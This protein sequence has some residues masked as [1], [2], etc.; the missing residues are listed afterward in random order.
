[1][2]GGVLVVGESVLDVVRDN[3]A[4]SEYPGGSPLNVACGLGRL[5]VDVSFLT[6]LGDDDAGRT[7]RD[8]LLASNV[9]IVDGS[10]GHEATSRATATIRPDGSADYGFEIAWM[11]PQA[12]SLRPARWVHVGSL[13]TF[14]SPG[15]ESVE[16]FLAALPQRPIVSYDPNIRSVLLPDHGRAVSQFEAF[17]RIA[18]V[19]KLS[20]EDA[21]WLYPAASEDQVVD[22]ILEL[23]ASVIAVTRG[24]DGARLQTKSSKVVVPSPR[25]EVVDTI[26]AGDS[27]MA[28]LITDLWESLLP[29][30]QERL[31]AAA[32]R[33]VTAAA[34][35]CARA[36]A[37]SPT[38]S[39]LVDAL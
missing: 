33:A 10:I 20:E 32:V 5:G 3:G 24:A 39:E 36:G 19:V 37:W 4:I 15:A 16:R 6:S 11:L 31:E 9:T 17:A 38:L 30:H 27:F 14:L 29:P 2:K 25:I 12:R 26:G 28:T 22:R 21:E 23:G 7:I 8:H 35:T 1:M 13:A 18:D 34:L